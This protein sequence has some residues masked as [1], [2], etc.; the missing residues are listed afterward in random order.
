[1]KFDLVFKLRST[2][3]Q[4]TH[5]ATLSAE[6]RDELLAWLNENLGGKFMAIQAHQGGM[7]SGKRY[8]YT[9]VINVS[10][11]QEILINEVTED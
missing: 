5:G 10:E 1:M 7:M 3:G 9:V 2:E 6:S 8:D 11:I 4:R